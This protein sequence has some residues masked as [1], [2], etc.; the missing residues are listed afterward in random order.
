MVSTEM[1]YLISHSPVIKD[2]NQRCTGVIDNIDNILSSC[3][4][5]DKAQEIITRSTVR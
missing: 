3:T 5:T 2:Q 1:V 4:T